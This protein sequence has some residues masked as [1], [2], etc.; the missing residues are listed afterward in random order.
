MS[1][2][3]GPRYSK[4]SR[5]I[6]TDSR[7]IALGDWPA[8]PQTLW[9]YLLTSNLQGP[10]PGLFA[11]GAGAVADVLGWEPAETEDHLC[12]LVRAGLIERHRRPA[13]IWIPKAIKH[14]QPTSP[15]QVI[16]WADFAGELPECELRDRAVAGITQAIESDALRERWLNAAPK[17]I[18][19]GI[20]DGIPDGIGDGIGNTRTR[21]RT[22]TRTREEQYMS[23]APPVVDAPRPPVKESQR[24]KD[25]KDLDRHWQDLSGARPKPNSAASKK[26]L[27]RWARYLKDHSVE[28]L[29]L[30]TEYIADSA[31]WRGDNNT[32][33]DLLKAG[34][35]KW[36]NDPEKVEARAE[37][38]RAWHKAGRPAQAAKGNAKQSNR[39][40]WERTIEDVKA[41]VEANLRAKGIDPDA[42]TH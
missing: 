15:G 41:E 35:G 13:L 40:P 2:S 1:Q 26:R 30:L 8:T 18:G 10:L 7:F 23:A 34:P 12:A 14:N 21:A 37:A 9:V 36:L 38:A 19:D 11:A 29:K 5:R 16:A 22:R 3:K 28:D 24:S 31:W 33:S 4:V 17:P 20:G 25:A 32:G 6:W 27:A 39:P 42:L